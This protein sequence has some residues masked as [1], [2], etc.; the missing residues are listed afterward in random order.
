MNAA[1]SGGPDGGE[2]A[3]AATYR[4]GRW[5]GLVAPGALALL[6][7][8]VPADVAGELWQL[9][10]EG[11][12]LGAW[13]E[14]L[15][16]AGIRALPSFAMVEHHDRGLRVLVRGGVEVVVG[17]HRIDGRSYATWREEVLDEIGE[18]LLR[19][20]GGDGHWWPIVAGLVPA[21]ELRASQVGS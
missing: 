14:Y 8:D 19:A 4:G 20:E 10:T 1:A 9:A 16:A 15:A 17:E 12:R 2:Q 21:A 7:P 6:H 5:H 13:V 18:V 3:A 11:K